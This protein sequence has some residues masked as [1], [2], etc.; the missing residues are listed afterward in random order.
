MEKHDE[1]DE[2][3]LLD[4][5]GNE[6]RFEHILTFVHEKERYVALEP[7]DGDEAESETEDEAEIVILK[8]VEKDGEDTYVPVENEVLLNEVFDTFLEL[9]DEIEEE[10]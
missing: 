1:L 2:I 8:V 5:M 3:V 9:M 6:S 10:E 4:E 7:I